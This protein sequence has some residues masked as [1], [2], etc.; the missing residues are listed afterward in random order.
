MAEEWKKLKEAEEITNWRERDKVSR[1][2]CYL[3]CWSTN[4]DANCSDFIG[5]FPTLSSVLRWAGGGRC[6]IGCMRNA[7]SQWRAVIMAS[8]HVSKT[9]KEYVLSACGMSVRTRNNNMYEK[10]QQRMKHI[11]V[12]RIGRVKRIDRRKMMSGGGVL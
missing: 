4:R 2:R 1:Q 6:E 3:F 10:Q 12:M 5:S 8:N 11:R 9:L 7:R